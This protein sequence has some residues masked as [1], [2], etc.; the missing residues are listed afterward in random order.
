MQTCS[1]CGK[2]PESQRSWVQCPYFNH[3]AICMDHC[4]KECKFHL[5]DRCMYNERKEMRERNIV[6]K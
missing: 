1:K 2:T 3:E 5:F 6:A 4:Y